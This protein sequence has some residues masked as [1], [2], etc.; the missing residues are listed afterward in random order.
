MA[1]EEKIVEW[2]VG[3]PDWQRMVLRRVA[4]G[5]PLSDVDYDTLVDDLVAGRPVAAVAFKLEHVPHSQPGGPQVQLVSVSNLK[6]V[7][8]LASETPLTFSQKGLTV[9]YG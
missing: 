6:N 9:V 2:S 1:L 5:E 3:K 4:D 7:N 8:A